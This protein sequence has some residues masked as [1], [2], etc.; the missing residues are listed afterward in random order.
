MCSAKE[1]IPIGQND[2][3]RKNDIRF[4]IAEEDLAELREGTVDLLVLVIIKVIVLRK[5]GQEN[6]TMEPILEFQILI[7]PRQHGD[8]ALIRRG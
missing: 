4:S 6:R 5:Q 2:F 1:S 7:Y 3:G 8:G